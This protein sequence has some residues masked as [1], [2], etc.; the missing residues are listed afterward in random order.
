MA[1]NPPHSPASPG[2]ILVVTPSKNEEAYLP[3][4]I[5]CMEAQTRKPDLW[6]LV[7]DGSTDDT[8]KIADEAAAR[9][10]DWIRVLH[11]PGGVA[12]R[13][14]PGVVEAFY[15]GLDLVDLE[16]F[17]F[18]CKLDGDLEFG[19]GL[20]EGLLRKGREDP[21]LG[22]WSGKFWERDDS[23]TLRLYRTGSEFTVGACKFYRRKAFQ[24]IGGFVREVM[25]DGIDCHR[26]RMRGWKAKSF[27]D[28]ELKIVHM[29]PMGSS[30]KSIFHGRRRWGWGQYFMGTHPLYLLGI[31]FYRLWE[32]P[33]ILGGL[34][35]F[36]G[37]FY[38]WITGAPR[39]EDEEFR[40]FLRSWQLKRLG[41]GFLSGRGGG[42]VHGTGSEEPA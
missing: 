1:P 18:L 29:R 8:G 25:W 36:L 27:P 23:G 32:R 5:A 42:K 19:P 20:F 16:E 40:R 30:S 4:T 9:H 10:P 22:T 12:R 28:P 34:N 15:A 35:I 7:D 39:Y 17:E 3:K 31:A 33:Y 14:G 26:C 24:E 6:I 11:R 21:R 38:A 2:K 13:V 41:L 37:Y